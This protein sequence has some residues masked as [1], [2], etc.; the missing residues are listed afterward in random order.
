MRMSFVPTTVMFLWSKTAVSGS[1]KTLLIIRKL[2]SPKSVI[3]GVE[4]G[5]GCFGT[6]LT[7]DTNG[8][9]LIEYAYCDMF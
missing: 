6:I 5:Q 4:V 2:I 3:K 9:V 8:D 1:M 7:I